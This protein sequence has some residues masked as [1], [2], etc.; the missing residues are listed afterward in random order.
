M[1]AFGHWSS[2]ALPQGAIRK[3]NGRELRDAFDGHHPTIAIVIARRRRQRRGPAPAV[4]SLAAPGRCGR[5]RSAGAALH[6]ARTE[7]RAPLRTLL[8]AV[9]GPAP[10]GLARAPEGNRPVRR[11]PGPPVPIVRRADDPR[12]DAP[13]LP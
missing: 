3:A 4:H 13:L 5:T 9:R 6:A 8:G 11:R 10:G 12:R 2:D 7:P 1:G